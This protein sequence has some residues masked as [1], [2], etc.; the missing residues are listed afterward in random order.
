VLLRYAQGAH[1][2]AGMTENLNNT[3]A[4]KIMFRNKHWNINMNKIE[5]IKTPL[6]QW[7]K[8]KINSGT[9]DLDSR[10][11]SL[12]QLQKIQEVIEYAV[13]QST[14]YRNHLKGFTGS[15]I[16]SIGDFRRIPFIDESDIRSHGGRMLCVSQDEINRIVTLNSSGTTGSPKRIY[17]T[18]DDQELTIDFFQHG[19]SVLTNPGDRVLILLPCDLPG[20]VGD[21]LASAIE[22]LGALPV[23]HGVVKSIPEALAKIEQEQINVIV[24]IPVQLLALARFHEAAGGSYTGVERILLSTDTVPV[25]ILNAL[26]EIF[27]C[28]VF[29]H[30]GMTEMGLGGGVD[31]RSHSGYHLREADLYFEII[32]PD[33]GEPVPDGEYGEVVFTTLTRRG[34]PLIRYRTGDISRFIQGVCGCGTVLRRMDYIRGRIS[35]DIKISDNRYLKLSELDEKIFSLPGVVDFRVNLSKEN[36]PRL[37]ITLFSVKNEIKSGIITDEIKIIPGIDELVKAGKLELYV[38]SNLCDFNYIPATGKRII[39]LS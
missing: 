31:C 32:D 36:P 39:H 19:M 10:E 22:R 27:G 4:L 11:L 3:L 20:S 35:G 5:K 8:G 17:F 30:Y 1:A 33:T 25:S 12:Y 26:Q 16:T 38:N 29:N 24:G 28:E 23:K 13:K 34:M 14:F 9:D 2:T 15:D 18:S 21:L 6:E 7:I 37:D